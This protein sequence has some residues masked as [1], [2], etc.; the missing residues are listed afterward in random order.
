[1]FNGKFANSTHVRKSQKSCLGINNRC[2]KEDTWHFGRH[3]DETTMEG[4]IPMNIFEQ[5]APKRFLHGWLCFLLAIFLMTGIGH[6]KDAPTLRVAVLKFGTVNWFLDTMQDKGFDVANGFKLEV[7]PLASKTATSVAFL[8][9]SVEAFVTDW[10]WAMGE[11][12]KGNAV[13]FLPYSSTLGALMVPGDS[14]AS[15]FKD[16]AGQRIGVA[17]G[18]LDKSWLLMQTLARKHGVENLAKA[19]EPVFGAP[20]L[21]NAQAGKGDLDAVLNFWHFAARL[22]GEGFRTLYSVDETMAKLGIEPAPPLI[23]FIH[24]EAVDDRDRQRWEGFA[25]A[26]AAT[27]RV[28]KTSDEAWDRVRKLMRASSDTEFMILRDTYRQGIL[29][30]WTSGHGEAAHKLFDLMAE[31]GGEKVIR[32]N[33]EF[34]PALFPPEGR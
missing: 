28:L 6:A 19:V 29:G 17:G 18:P 24:L 11:R 10:F 22:K 4:N 26:M 33:V 14:S 23:G 34:D 2:D 21:L 30:E 5:S 16:L 27:N 15:G 20:P 25:A 1:M 12:S 32:A 9:G 31:I 13:S 3:G 8:S 7:V